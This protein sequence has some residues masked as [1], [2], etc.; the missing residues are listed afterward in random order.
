MIGELGRVWVSVRADLKTLNKDFN[1]AF[2][3]VNRQ[4]HDVTRRL[5]RAFAGISMGALTARGFKL[6]ASFEK[7][8]VS[9]EAMLGSAAKARTMLKEIRDLT[10]KSPFGFEELKDDMKFLLAVG[11]QEEKLIDDMKMLSSVVAGTGAD[12]HRLAKAYADVSARGMLYGQ[13]IRQFAEAGVPLVKLLAIEMGKSTAEILKMSEEGQISFSEVEK[14]LHKLTSESG[15]FGTILEEQ[16]ETVGGQFRQLRNEMDFLLTDMFD[17]LKPLNK[18]ILRTAK[19]LIVGMGSAFDGVHDDFVAWAKE[20]ATGLETIREQ[21]D[22]SWDIVMTQM[23]IHLARGEERI[24]AFFNILPSLVEAAKGTM[25]EYWKLLEKSADSTWDWI[26][27]QGP[28]A[29]KG[30]GKFLWGSFWKTAEN[31]WVDPFKRANQA[32]VPPHLKQD[33]WWRQP[34]SNWWQDI[35]GIAQDSFVPMQKTNRRTS[36]EQAGLWNSTQEAIR[37]VWEKAVEKIHP[38]DLLDAMFPTDSPEIKRMQS[39]LNRMTGEFGKHWADNATDMATRDRQREN[40]IR[41]IEGGVPEIG[42]PKTKKGRKA[43]AMVGIA[44]LGRRIQQEIL[45]KDAERQEKMLRLQEENNRQN[46]QMLDELRDTKKGIEDLE[47]G[48]T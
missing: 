24:R 6:A 39:E 34:T 22:L 23:G 33:A 31:I 10:R 7:T 4:A 5:N 16:V 12:F 15:K 25:K 28:D 8:Q 29:L 41:E 48:L 26:T 13:E 11:I 37:A 40:R 19:Q 42:D 18:E 38:K 2:G 43:D 47:L 9:L 1:S 27:K 21:W 46:Q 35:K 44:E 17:A 32:M 3:L 14:V 30:T 36:N 20:M 45:D